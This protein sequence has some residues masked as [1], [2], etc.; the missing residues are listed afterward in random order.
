MTA[1]NESDDTTSQVE[2]PGGCARRYYHASNGCAGLRPG[3]LLLPHAQTGL[4]PW[5]SIYAQQEH[6]WRADRV[7]LSGT[8][9]DAADWVGNWHEDGGTVVYEVEAPDAVP[10]PVDLDPEGVDHGSSP[11]WHAAAARVVRV[12]AA[13]AVVVRDGR[14]FVSAGGAATG[15]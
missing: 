11:Q 4:S 3:D 10:L 8:A 7:W 9:T 1:S 14:R 6:A 5:A 13:P 15:S 12:L 2:E